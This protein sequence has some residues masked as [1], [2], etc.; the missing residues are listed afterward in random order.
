MPDKLL[1]IQTDLTQI[2]KIKNKMANYP[3]FVI[4]QGL[5]AV[6]GYLNS[7]EFLSGFYPPSRAGD[8]FIWSSEKQRRAFFA[9]NGFGRGI[10][11]QRTYEL[12]DSGH[13]EVDKKY[14]S[15]YITYENTAPYAVWVIG[16]GT[17]TVGHIARGWRPMPE[18]VLDKRAEIFKTFDYGTAGAWEKVSNVVGGISYL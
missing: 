6:G 7:D 12:K 3:P 13:F 2:T 18:Q 14:S 17:Q 15:L 5:E 8:P 9:T 11:T 16:R 1:D 10:P 4:A